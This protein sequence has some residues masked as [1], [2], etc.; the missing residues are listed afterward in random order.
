[1]RL[2]IRQATLQDIDVVSD[3][4][5]EAA[6]WLKQSGMPLWRQ[7]ELHLNNISTEVRSGLFFLAECDGE[8]AGTIKYQLEDKL[9]WPDVPQDESAFVH[10]L[11]IKRRFAGGEVSSAL[12]LW[13]IARTNALGRRYLRLDCEVSRLRLRALFE[14]MGFRFHSNRQVG[15]YY[16]ARYEYD[17]KEISSSTRH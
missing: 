8:P 17:V 9:F 2:S 16:V 11:A 15:P 3:I 1:M 6:A 14:R 4:L 5:R 12:L 10:R 7:D 13:A